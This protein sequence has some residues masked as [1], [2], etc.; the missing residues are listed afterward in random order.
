LTLNTSVFHSAASACLLLG[1]LEVH[2]VPQ[3]YFLSPK[4]CAGILRRADKRG[5]VLPGAL[6]R[7]LLASLGA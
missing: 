7:A 5:R 1:V 3:K 2:D 6:S 4:A